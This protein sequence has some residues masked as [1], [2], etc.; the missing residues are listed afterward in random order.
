MTEGTFV[1]SV[2][3]KTKAEDGEGKSITGSERVAIE[4]TG[5]DLVTI[6]LAG[7]Y[8]ENIHQLNC[9]V[10]NHVKIG[11]HE[12][13]YFQNVGL[14]AMARAETVSCESMGGQ[15]KMEAVDVQ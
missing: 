10:N 2:T 15:N 11:L 6:F 13:T 4:E 3:E 9:F 5:E 7:N 12:D 14:N 1:K 8:A